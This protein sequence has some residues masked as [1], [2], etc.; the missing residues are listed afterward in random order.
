MLGKQLR[1]RTGRVHKENVLRIHTKNMLI[2]LG[3]TRIIKCRSQALQHPKSM[4]IPNELQSRLRGFCYWIILLRLQKGVRRHP[5]SQTMAHEAEIS[6]CLNH[7]RTFPGQVTTGYMLL[8]LPRC[9]VR[10]SSH[11][12]LTLEIKATI[13]QPAIWRPQ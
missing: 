6:S 13:R 4:V 10:Q 8:L 1:T 7:L 2:G 12:G 3:T 5:V 11:P 9:F